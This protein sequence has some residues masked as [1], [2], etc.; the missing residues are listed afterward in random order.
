[1]GISSFPRDSSWILPGDSPGAES[2]PSEYDGE[3]QGLNI[4]QRIVFAQRKN[5]KNKN[6]YKF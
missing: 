4:A 1:M 6:I 2:K 5:I 3:T